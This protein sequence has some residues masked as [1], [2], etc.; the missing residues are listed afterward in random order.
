[1]T[2]EEHSA[3]WHQLTVPTVSEKL[4]RSSYILFL[5]KDFVNGLQL[6]LEV[7][8]REVFPVAHSVDYAPANKTSLP[9]VL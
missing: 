3:C 6:E 5:Q 7:A 4:G 9:A 1:M 8:F 2:T